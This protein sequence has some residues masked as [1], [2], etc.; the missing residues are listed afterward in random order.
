M[1][2]VY[3]L[4]GSNMGERGALLESAVA[5]LIE[6]L[7]PDY[8]EVEDLSDAV[9][10][11]DIYETAPWGFECNDKFLNQAFVCLTDLDAREVLKICKEI[12]RE[13]GRED[14]LPEYDEKGERIYRSR[15]IDIDILLFDRKEE[16]GYL[17]Q[18]VDTVE[19]QVPHKRLH[20]RL[21]ALEPLAEIAG[22]YTHPLLGKSINVLKKELKRREK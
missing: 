1:N 22:N 16:S 7:L 12:E 13:L 18:V 4:L 11:S 14:L 19:L 2:R 20:E 17:P 21:F 5:L 3:L 9:N 6:K 10:T 15:P 8:L